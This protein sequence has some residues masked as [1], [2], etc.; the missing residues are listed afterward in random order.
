M[1]VIRILGVSLCIFSLIFA[2]FSELIYTEIIF[3]GL[4]VGGT[5]LIKS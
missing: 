3:V 1:K 2:V 4:F 5:I